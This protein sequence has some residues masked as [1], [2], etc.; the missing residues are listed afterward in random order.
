MN[1]KNNTFDVYSILVF[2]N[3]QNIEPFVHRFIFVKIDRNTIDSYS[4][5]RSTTVFLPSKINVYASFL[6]R[7]SLFLYQN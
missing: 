1:K 5:T 7:S 3:G 4:E 2:I 6:I